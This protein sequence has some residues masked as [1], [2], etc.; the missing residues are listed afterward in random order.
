VNVED[1]SSEANVTHLIASG[2]VVA[3]CT[4]T[5]N[6]IRRLVSEQRAFTKALEAQRE[7]LSSDR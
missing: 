5:S 2:A 4:A 1:N 6:V 7:H 3:I